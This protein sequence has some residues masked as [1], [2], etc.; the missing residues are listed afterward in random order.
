MHTK[1]NKN[2]E[3]IFIRQKKKTN[4]FFLIKEMVDNVKNRSDRVQQFINDVFPQRLESVNRLIM[5]NDVRNTGDLLVFY[6]RKT[7]YSFG[8]AGIVIGSTVLDDLEPVQVKG[9]RIRFDSKSYH[10]ADAGGALF[11]PIKKNGVVDFIQAGESDFIWHEMFL[12]LNHDSPTPWA[13]FIRYIGPLASQVRAC[14]A[15]L[16]EFL[17]TEK[18]FH[19]GGLQACVN[20]LFTKCERK[21]V[22]KLTSEIV[23]L[24]HSVLKGEQIS[25][26]CSSIVILVY[27]IAFLVLGH[28][29]LIETLPYS[30]LACR[31][32]HLFDLP[33]KYPAYWQLV[34][35][36]NNPTAPILPALLFNFSRDYPYRQ[37]ALWLLTGHDD[38][39]LSFGGSHPTRHH[40]EPNYPQPQSN[41][42]LN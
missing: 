3:S 15:I 6:P 37:S 27:Q 14:V 17:V 5:E 13:G 26:I 34:Q 39:A 23:E 31:P 28:P 42:L 4:N 35:T 30:I 18:I 25:T 1:I 40:P 20:V 7:A 32:S 8:H 11:L 9:G 16:T 19:H 22:D 2:L 33:K 36:I 12:N 29:E 21:D 24:F 41:P 10:V 38:L